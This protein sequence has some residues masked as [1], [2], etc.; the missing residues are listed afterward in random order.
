MG[1]PECAFEC[2]EMERKN[3]KKAKRHTTL[4]EKRNSI[5][6]YSDAPWL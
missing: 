2:K 5:A 6:I 4:K 1:K 3:Q